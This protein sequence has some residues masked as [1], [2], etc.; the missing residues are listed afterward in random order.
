MP[1]LYGII[2]STSIDLPPIYNSVWSTFL[3]QIA[4]S[5]GVPPVTNW[6]CF[7][8]SI[9]VLLA[10][11]VIYSLMFVEMRRKSAIVLTSISP[12]DVAI[13]KAVSYRQRTVALQSFLICFFIGL[14]ATIFALAGFVPV[15]LP[16]VKLATISL[17][18]C[19]GIYSLLSD[20]LSLLPNP[21]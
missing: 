11:V 17:Q 8:N 9:W 12:S 2:G 5:P 4:L 19:S 13:H 14:V 6:Y 15:P 21:L 16:L 7:S 18:L 3:F 20:V 10:L 1:I